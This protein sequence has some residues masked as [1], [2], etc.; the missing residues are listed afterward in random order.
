LSDDNQYG[1]PF[2]ITSV[3]GVGPFGISAYFGADKM[4]IGGNLS[5]FENEIGITSSS[6]SITL[7][8]ISSYFGVGGN[9]K[10]SMNLDQTLMVVPIQEVYPNIR[11]DN[12]NNVQHNYAF[13]KF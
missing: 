13:Q 7:L 3:Y 9:L 12:T 4:T 2:R 11:R 10:V 8:D 6:R 1:G 5:I